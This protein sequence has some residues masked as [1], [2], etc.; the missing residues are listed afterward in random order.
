MYLPLQ[1]AAGIR[2]NGTQA[3]PLGFG[4]RN[5]NVPSL[6]QIHKATPSVPR[7]LR[8][9]KIELLHPCYLVLAWFERRQPKLFA[10]TLPAETAPVDAILANLV[11]DDARRRL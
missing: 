10:G 5:R 2:L 9:G 11:V 4:E 7:P 8:R 6:V 3:L 1:P